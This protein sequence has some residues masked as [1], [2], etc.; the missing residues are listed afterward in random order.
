MNDDT[1]NRDPEKHDPARRTI[2]TEAL[3]FA[4]LFLVVGAAFVGCRVLREGS[5]VLDFDMQRAR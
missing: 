4:L 1:V 2:A 5:R 3:V